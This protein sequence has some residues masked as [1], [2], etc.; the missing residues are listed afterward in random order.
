LIRLA[1]LAAAAVILGAG[2]SWAS[3]QERPAQGPSADS[4]AVAGTFRVQAGVVLQQSGLRTGEPLSFRDLQRAVTTLYSTGNYDDVAIEQVNVDG[5]LV[6]IIRVVER[7]VLLRWSL[8]GA[9][10]LSQGSLRSQVV[11]LDGRPL[12]RAAL[13]RS[14]ASI[15]SVYRSEGFYRS[16]VRPI[17]QYSDDSTTV[18]VVFDIVEGHRVP[19]AQ[20]VI[21]DNTQLTDEQIA[22]AMKTGTEGFWWFQR[23]EYDEEKLQEDI[24][25]RLPQ[26]YGEQGYVDFQVVRDTL[27]VDEQ[28][29]KGIL[30]IA[31]R[32][33]D[34]HHLGTFE[35]V[36]NRRFSTEQ[37]E[38]LYPFGARSRG[39]FGL[40]GTFTSTVFDQSR[41]DEATQQLHNLYTN[42]GYI[43]V[44]IRP[45]LVRRRDAEGR[46]VVDLRWVINEGQPATIRRV[47]IVGNSHTHERVIRDA[48]LVIPGDVYNQERLIR[49]FQNIINLGFFEQTMPPPDVQPAN[50]QGDVDI[51]FHVEERRTGNVNVGASLGQGTGIG[52]FIGL[53]EPN[54][55]GRG[56]RGRIQWQ[57][58]RNINDIDLSYTDPAFRGTRVSATLRLHN[59]R[60]RYTIADLG[61]IQTRGFSLQLGFPLLDRFNRLF[62]SYTLEQENYQGSASNPT[63]QSAFRCV[64]CLR[65]AIGLSILRDTRINL[66]F[67][68]GGTMHQGSIAFNGGPLG[69]TGDFRRVDLE[70]RWYA[71]LGQMGGGDVGSQPAIFVLGFKA[72]AGFVFGDAG[73]FFRQLFALGGTQ[74]GVPVRGYEEF[75]IT[76]RG[77]NPFAQNSV[78]SPDAF[79]ASYLALTGEVGLRLSQMLYLNAFVDAA[80]N[81]AQAGEFNPTRLFR[82]AGVGVSL[83]SPLGPLGL[84]YAYGFDRVG[85]IGQPNPGWKLHFKLGNFF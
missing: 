2:P 24:Y 40:G 42:Q 30:E 29:G 54:L 73:P 12:D 21:S 13:E 48:L 9:E 64:D 26:H 14:R 8:R 60:L 33:G 22:G 69:G 16:S 62:V 84:D 53:D 20:I 38:A 49:S 65:S 52:G 80:N 41:W 56:K 11:L 57:F 44:Q 35:I 82:G 27:L 4:I 67:P 76:P 39:L 68:T 63:F 72:R 71:P 25:E 74:F 19:V 37:L 7:P 31:V 45:E 1:H 51:I 10:R 79:G 15:D 77:F 70:G 46:A 55:F 75:S 85:P 6:L 83:I 17:I 58:G 23:G 47:D 78:A 43:Y 28:T 61:R 34:Q 3:A 5:R 32:E 81:W 18:R 50:E 66:P 59:T 36:G